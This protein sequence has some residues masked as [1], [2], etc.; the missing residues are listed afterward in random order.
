MVDEAVKRISRTEDLIICVQ[1]ALCKQDADFLVSHLRDQLD[2]T[3]SIYTST[4][5]AVVGA[6]SGPG[7]IGIGILQG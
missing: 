5:G 1:H 2:Y 7:A 6:H 4:V 3:G